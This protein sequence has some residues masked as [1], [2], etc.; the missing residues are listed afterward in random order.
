MDFAVPAV[1]KV[2]RIKNKNL[3]IIKSC[4]RVEKAGDV[5]V[6]IVLIVVSALGTV[7]KDLVR[8]LEE[9]ETRRMATI[10]TIASLILAPILRRILRRPGVTQTPAKYHQLKLT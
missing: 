5:R 6:M 9:L 7:F 3:D 10:Q 1:H 2:K 4:K 8:W